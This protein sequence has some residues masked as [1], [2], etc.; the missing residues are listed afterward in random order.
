M[1]I[2]FIG[3]VVGKSGRK[4]VCDLL[5]RINNSKYKMDLVICNAENSAHGKGITKKIY[6]ELISYGVN[7]GGDF[8]LTFGKVE[9]AKIFCIDPFSFF[10]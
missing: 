2:L 6:D 7:A 1:N 4:S 5:S 9:N 10:L 3:D 8:K